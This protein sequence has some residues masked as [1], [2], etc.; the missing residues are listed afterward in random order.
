[1]SA[2]Q[3]LE[4]LIGHWTG[5]NRL[6]RPWLNPPDAES[7]SESSATVDEV[8]MG[9]FITIEY[10][11]SLDGQPQAGFML[12]GRENNNEEVKATWVDSWHMSD[13]SMV[14]DG[15]IDANGVVNVRGSY[16]APPGPDWGWRIVIEATSDNSF[17]IVMYNITP[18]GEQS[19]AVESRYTRKS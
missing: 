19:L 6:Y 1:M 17:T 7:E 10:T 13:K 15:G 3:S 14:F 4:K 11:W 16:A 8:A 5:T 12:L 2:P 9:K 18:D